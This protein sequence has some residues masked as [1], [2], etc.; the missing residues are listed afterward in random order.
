M[1]AHGA[2]MN[3]VAQRV[4]RGDKIVHRQAMTAGFTSQLLG[5]HDAPSNAATRRVEGTC[6]VS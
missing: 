2:F 3:F 1:F 4:E 5:T 6:V